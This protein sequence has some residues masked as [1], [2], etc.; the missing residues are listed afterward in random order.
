MYSRP[1]SPPLEH[2][3]AY[4][5]EEYDDSRF[6]AEEQEQ[7]ES[8]SMTTTMMTRESPPEAPVDVEQLKRAVHMLEQTVA[9]VMVGKPVRHLSHSVVSITWFLS[10]LL[11]S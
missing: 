2:A 10:A 5:Q 6:I 1:S 4:A 9:A 3:V 7:Q 8:S 11:L